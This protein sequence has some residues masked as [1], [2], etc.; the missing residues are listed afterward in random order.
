MLSYFQLV[1][2]PSYTAAFLRVVN[3]P[4]RSIGDK[5]AKAILLAAQKYKL[6]PFDIAV[7]LAN[8]SQVVTGITE[9]QRKGLREFVTAV[10]DLRNSADK[11]RCLF[12]ARKEEELTKSAGYER[13][14]PHRRTGPQ[15]SLPGSSRANTWTRRE[16]PLG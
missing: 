8:R 13:F 15:G 2:N 1:E 10:R 7:K 9:P 16:G 14:G 3:V 11:V 6:S 12:P 5:T 4:T